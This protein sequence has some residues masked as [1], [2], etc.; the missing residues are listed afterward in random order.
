MRADET[1]SLYTLNRTDRLE[2]I[3]EVGSLP[4]GSI[5]VIG[6]HRLSQKRDLA[7][8]FANAIA[9]FSE[10][11]LHGVIALAPAD[12]RH[13]AIR[14]RIVAASHD[15]HKG[16]NLVARCWTGVIEIVGFRTAFQQP[17]DQRVEIFNGLRAN[18][19]VNVGKA[20]FEILL[21]AFRRAAG[22][23]DLASRLLRLPFLQAA[24]CRAGLILSV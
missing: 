8:T 13:D 9:Y 7:R 12:I 22:D 20:V 3:R 24:D 4:A 19:K 15:G 17:L 10:H 16:G 2:K 14:A 5:A 21:R 18:N 11:L 6:V 23:Y 1:D